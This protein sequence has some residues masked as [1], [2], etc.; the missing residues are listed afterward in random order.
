M[1][2]RILVDS[3]T[4]IDFLRQPDKKDTLLHQLS[5]KHLLCASII[6]HTEIYAGK[7][8]WTKKGQKDISTIFEGITLLPINTEISKSAGQL[9]ASTSIDIIDALIA[10]TAV[11]NDLPLA[12]LNIKHFKDIPELI[13]LPID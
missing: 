8:A 2:S 13:L 10:S 3:C 9:R 7:S 6:T 11:Q 4:I 1:N 12:T 5:K